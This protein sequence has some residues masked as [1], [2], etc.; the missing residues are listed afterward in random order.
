MGGRW[1][2]HC[3]CGGREGESIAGA[4]SSRF[5]ARGRS[6]ESKGKASAIGAA[7]PPTIL[8]N[9]LVAVDALPEAVGVLAALDSHGG[10]GVA[11]DS[12]VA[13]VENDRGPGPD[14]RAG[15]YFPCCGGI[16]GLDGTINGR[17]I[18]ALFN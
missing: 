6:G 10:I 7:I 12:A 16:H 15:R 14:A 3:Y 11:T 1:L 18:R 4:A 5:G 8:L 13:S 2:P 9:C 17:D